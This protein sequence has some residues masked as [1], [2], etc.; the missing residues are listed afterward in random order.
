VARTKRAYGLLYQALPDDLRRLVAAVPQGYAYGLWS[1][2]EKRFQS[3]EQDNVGELWDEF[4]QLAQGDDESFDQYKARVDRVYGLLEHAKDKPSRGQ[5]THRLLWKLS[6]QYNAAVLALRAGGKLKESDKIDWDEIVAFVNNHERSQQR[7]DAG[8]GGQMAAAATRGVR[9]SRG[10]ECFNCGE[11]GHLARNCRNQRKERRR[12]G[13]QDDEDPGNERVRPG[14][15]N[16]RA[17]AALSRGGRGG[18]RRVA[19][20]PMVSSDEDERDGERSYAAVVLRGETYGEPEEPS[21]LT[22]KARRGGYCA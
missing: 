6:P 17:A 16:E 19:F 5:Y 2:L 8:D 15:K 13:E 1:W 9:G 10:M 20:H 12:E 18:V 4:T 22:T 21:K 7:L 3:T 14:R 11:I